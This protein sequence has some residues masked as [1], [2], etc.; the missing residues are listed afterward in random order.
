MADGT[1]SDIK[2]IKLGKIIKLNINNFLFKQGENKDKMKD[3]EIV[4]IFCNSAIADEL[5]AE[6]D[7]TSLV[8]SDLL[9]N[10]EVIM[11]SKNDFLTWLYKDN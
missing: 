8:I 7:R 11:V 2:K 5:S 1:V 10:S 6:I 3:D 9:S 4:V